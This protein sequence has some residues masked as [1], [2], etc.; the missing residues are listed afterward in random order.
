MKVNESFT[1]KQFEIQTRMTLD[2][3][4]GV[5]SRHIQTDRSI[6]G[7]LLSKEDFVGCVS[8]GGFKV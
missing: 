6:K 3:A 8:P 4:V 5:L 7:W 1:Y 2:E